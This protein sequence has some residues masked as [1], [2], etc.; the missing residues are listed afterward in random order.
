MSDKKPPH[1]I[2]STTPEQRLQLLG[3]YF[4]SYLEAWFADILRGIAFE[5]TIALE[6]SSALIEMGATVALSIDDGAD[7]ENDEET[8]KRARD[9]SGDLI[10]RLIDRHMLVKSRGEL[11]PWLE[12]RARTAP[13]PSPDVAR[14]VARARVAMD[15]IINETDLTKLHAHAKSASLAL[16]I[17]QCTCELVTVRPKTGDDFERHEL[18]LDPKCP[19]HGGAK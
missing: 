8:A 18:K 16:S 6:L 19:L 7:D 11:V 4:R 3:D 13:K 5:P 10:Q 14:D 2:A 17:E 12:A 1:I 15:A 9:A